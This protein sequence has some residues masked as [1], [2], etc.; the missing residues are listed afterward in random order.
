[1]ML[2]FLGRNNL[3]LTSL[4]IIERVFHQLFNCDAIVLRPAY[5]LPLV[6]VL[7]VFHF[8]GLVPP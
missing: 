5:V 4:Q 1:M 6:V 7:F 2:C 8:L 3:D